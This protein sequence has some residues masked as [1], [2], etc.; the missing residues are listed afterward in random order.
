[1]GEEL[2]VRWSVGFLFQT[3]DR[4]HLLEKEGIKS[5][6]EDA[7][8]HATRG[9]APGLFAKYL[10]AFWFTTGK[11]RRALSGKKVLDPQKLSSQL[12]WRRVCTEEDERRRTNERKKEQKGR[13]SLGGKPSVTIFL[14]F[15][16]NASNSRYIYI[17][18]S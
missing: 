2:S 9:W 18:E 10:N 15:R 13:R 7:E 11:G 14:N 16:R 6:G 12:I 1:M 17:R 5:D 8:S 4:N 3:R